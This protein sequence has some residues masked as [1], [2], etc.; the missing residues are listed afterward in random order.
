[1][2]DPAARAA[3]P[4][5]PSGWLAGWRKLAGAERRWL[6]HC[7]VWL[8]IIRA[9]LRLRGLKRT[10]KWLDDRAA[11]E[12]GPPGPGDLA[13]AWRLAELAAVAGRRGPIAATC[14]P[15]ALLVNARLRQRGF[16]SEL[17]FGVRRR[18]NRL[19]AHAW[20]ELAGVALAQSEPSHAPL[21]AAGAP[22]QPP[23]PAS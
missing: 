23:P 12:T 2:S 21:T 22:A 15:Q 7:L 9:S 13:Q 4:R 11:A 3:P 6:L 10:R 18:G 20:V 16:P 1:M 14:L 19:D 5:P 8:P 17:Q